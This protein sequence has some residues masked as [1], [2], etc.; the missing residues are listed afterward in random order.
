MQIFDLFRKTLSDRLNEAQIEQF[1]AHFEISVK[2][3]TN[4][5]LFRVYPI[6]DRTNICGEGDSIGEA[7]DDLIR[8]LK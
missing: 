2:D 6:L 8:E 3:Q 4:K 7:V 5:P 1:Q